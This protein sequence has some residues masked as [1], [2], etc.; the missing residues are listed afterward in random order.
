MRLGLSAVRTTVNFGTWGSGAPA[1]VEVVQLAERLGYDSVWTAEA[2]GTDAVTPLAWLAAHTTT[3]KLG[4]AVMQM[5][6]RPPTT[7]AMTAATLDLLSGGRF[8]LGLGVSGPVV[9]EGWHGAAFASP[10]ERTREYLKVVRDA[11]SRQP[12]EHHGRH[13]RYPY[14]G[15]DASGLAAPVR[16]MFRPRRPSVPI[17]IAAMGPKNVALAYELADGVM[18]AFYSPYREDAFF[19]FTDSPLPRSIEVAPFVPVAIGENHQACRD[20]LKPSFAFWFGGMGAKGLNFYNR[21]ISRLGFEHEASVIQ[22][23]YTKGLRAQAAAAVPDALVDELSLCGPRARIAEQLA[24]WEESAVTTMILTGADVEAITTV[25]E[26][27]L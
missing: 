8:I 2:S 6:A 14:D 7:T 11:L 27:A 21:F 22:E 1:N 13:Y 9:V 10:L 15:D 26:L 17:Y 23:L 12:V 4:T 25:A 20:R 16:L 18:P 3:I 5:T 19:S 24:A